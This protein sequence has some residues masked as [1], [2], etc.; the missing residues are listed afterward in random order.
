[1]NHDDHSRFALREAAGCFWL[2]DTA[3]PGR[4]YRQPIR[5]NEAGA[6]IW[7]AIS[8][9]K[10]PEEIASDMAEPDTPADEI[11]E[12]IRSF[13]ADIEIELQRG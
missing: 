11:I 4:P 12:D 1:M 2:V 7:Q 6:E 9:G 10:K 8:E 13:I 3:Q 5:L